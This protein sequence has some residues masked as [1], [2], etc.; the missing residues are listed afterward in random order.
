MGRVEGKVAFI[1]GA[2]GGIGEVT[3]RLFASEGAKVAIAARSVD[4]GEAVA[5]SRMKGR[6]RSGTA[7]AILAVRSRAARA[8]DGSPRPA[9][10][11]APSTA[12]SISSGVSI[13]GGRSKPPSST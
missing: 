12:A 7:A 13:R 4:K 6:S 10:H 8:S 11:W 1:T 2:S 9:T 5:G 3:A